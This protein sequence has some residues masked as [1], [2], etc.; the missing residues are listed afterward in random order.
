MKNLFHCRRTFIA[1]FGIACT[2]YLGIH[3]GIDVSLAIMGA[4]ASICG[5]NSAEAIFK[6]KD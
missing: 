1:A 2:T 5:A 6:K 3:N 4:V